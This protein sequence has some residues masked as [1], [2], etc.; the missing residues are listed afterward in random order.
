MPDK[1]TKMA[2]EARECEIISALER[3]QARI[4]RMIAAEERRRQ[5]IQE[6]LEEEIKK[7]TTLRQ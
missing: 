5:E 6:R 1:A 7:L 3:D 2:E 4:D